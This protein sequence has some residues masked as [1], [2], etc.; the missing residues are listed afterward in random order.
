M[1]EFQWTHPG[2]HAVQGEVTVSGYDVY[3][4]RG[5]LYS[6][7]NV[8]YSYYVNGNHYQQQQKAALKFYSFPIF[9]NTKTGYLR[10]E[11]ARRFSR[12]QQQ[13]SYVI[14]VNDQQPASSRFFSSKQAFYCSGSALK[15]FLAGILFMLAVFALVGFLAFLFRN[16]KAPSPVNRKQLQQRIIKIILIIFGLLFTIYLAF[17]IYFKS[18]GKL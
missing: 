1:K 15:N 16:Y 14:M 3:K 12:I 9:S 6:F 17:L 4:Q 7:V 13:K 10:D 8:D 11:V 2:Y 5:N 18:T